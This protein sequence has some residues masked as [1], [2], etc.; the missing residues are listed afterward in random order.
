MADLEIKKKR[1][2]LKTKKLEL[3]TQLSRERQKRLEV[4]GKNI[5]LKCKN[6]DSAMT[7]L[8]YFISGLFVGGCVFRLLQQNHVQVVKL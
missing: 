7:S 1:L 5:A 4:E 8:K 3:L 2:Q 6:C